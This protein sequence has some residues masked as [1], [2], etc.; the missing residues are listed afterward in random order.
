M[1]NHMFAL[2]L[3]VLVMGMPLVAQT[4]FFS[5]CASGTAIE[6]S[7]SIKAGADI[8]ARDQDGWTPLLV[9]ASNNSSYEVITILLKAGA[10]IEVRNKSGA[11]PLIAAAAFNTNPEVISVLVKAGADIQARDNNFGLTPL[12]AAAAYNSN[13]EVITSLLK[14][15]A[16]IKDR[17]KDEWT[18]L[19]VA[20][21]NNSNPDVITRLLKAGADIKEKNNA[22][23]TA[24]YYAQKNE[25]LIRSQQFAPD[26]LKMAEASRLLY[27]KSGI[28]AV[29]AI[30]D[31]GFMSTSELAQKKA[32]A[33]AAGTP[34]LK[35]A[36][37]NARA[38]LEIGKWALEPAQ[39]TMVVGAWDRD[40]K[41]WPLTVTSLIKTFPVSM[42]MVWNISDVVDQKALYDTVLA[43]MKAKTLVARLRYRLVWQNGSIWRQVPDVLMIV[44]HN[45]DVTEQELG[46]ISIDPMFNRWDIDSTNSTKVTKAGLIDLITVAGGSF[47]MGDVDH[48]PIHTVKISSFKMAR[49]EVTQAQYRA[50][51]GKSPN[52]LSEGSEAPDRPVEAVSWYD[53]VVFCNLLSAKEGLTAAYT[54]TEPKVTFNQRANG[55]RLPTEA[56]W[57]F[58]ARGG[59]NPY[60]TTYAG[61]NDLDAVGWFDVNSGQTTHSVATKVANELGLYDMSGNVCEWCQ[62]GYADYRAETQTNP[63]GE[64]LGENRV[65]RGGSRRDGASDCTVS[66]RYSEYPGLQINGV[67]FRVVRP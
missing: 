57:E 51:S 22:G 14:A 40:K 67:G 55:Y 29:S 23:E 6:V 24:F 25:K 43:Q 27:E 61:S 53:A 59:V 2:T 65:Y 36:W 52:G 34:A 54:I 11:T 7:Q 45:S 28:A 63:V 49:T 5:L 30:V 62:D 39:L 37:E 12:M 21:S 35:T 10:N 33:Q 8:E 56:E 3:G 17:D 19:M 38:D 1:R 47:K 16:D 18:P 15:G 26:L 32:E 31:D 66:C 20:A 64:A 48:G 4:D 42:T 46:R 9:A 60:G 13:P 58:A 44:G 50:I 41:Q